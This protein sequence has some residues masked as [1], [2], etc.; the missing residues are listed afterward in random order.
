MKRFASIAMLFA[1]VF[2]F[3]A[4][5]AAA[6]EV[7]M[8]GDARIHANF[9]SDINYTGWNAKGTNTGDPLTIWERFRLRSDF[10]ANEGLKFRLGIRVNNKAWGNDTFTVDNPA[11]SIDVYQAFLQ[12]KWPGTNVEFTVGLQDIDLPI[13]SSALLNSNPVFGGT[14]A[15][16]AVVS[17]PVTDQF[18]AVAGFTRL[19]DTN[20]D[21]DTTTRQVAD[22]FD[23]YFLVLPITLDGFSATPWGMVAVAGRDAGYSTTV[24]SSPRYTDQSLATNLASAA[25]MLS[26]SGFKQAQTVF[27]WV[28]SS[29]A[30]TA[31]DPFKFY[32]DVIYGEGAGNQGSRQRKGMFFD[33]ATEYTGLDLLTP[34]LTFWYSTGENGSMRDGSERMPTVVGSWGPSTSFLFDSSQAFAGGHMGLNPMGS[35]GIAFSLNKISFIQDLTHRLTF[36]YAR[37]TNQARALRDANALWGTGNYVQMG[38][39]LT[40][41]EYVMAI[42][43]DNQYNIY[44]NLAAIVEAG[45]AH[46]DFQSSVW[47]RRLVNQSKDGDAWKVAFGLQY[48]F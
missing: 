22:E 43:F 41:N 32:A 23:G 45:W 6:T 37:G 4:L 42:N 7:R 29:F 21:F 12:F 28:G 1:M 5:A 31:L 9:W 14:R 47:G 46:G 35:W 8:T 26:P 18:K 15:A 48:K 20:K 25:Y 16:A 2:G 44:E 33:V 38:R 36:S 17:I 24:G 3:A 27:W 39:D 11:T 34:Q 30:V 40:V 19:L 13:S 10:I